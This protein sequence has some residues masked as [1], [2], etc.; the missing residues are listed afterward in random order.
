MV[1]SD[2]LYDL[3][4]SDVELSEI[5]VVCSGSY[6]LSTFRCECGYLVYCFVDCWGL[7]IVMLVAWLFIRLLRFRCSS[8]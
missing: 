7:V 8:L 1:Y 5:L 6:V 4:V 2:L 3:D